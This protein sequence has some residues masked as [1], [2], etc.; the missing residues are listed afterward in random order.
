MKKLRFVSLLLAL[1]VLNVPFLPAAP[2][3][4]NYE[5]PSYTRKEVQALMHLLD[6][7]HY[8]RDA[9]T[10]KDFKQLI[11]DYMAELD[12]QRLFFT[13]EDKADFQKRYPALFQNLITLGTL[14]SAF[15]IYSLYEKRA[16]ERINWIFA[17][18]AK[19][20]DVS[21]HDSYFIDRSKA[22][23]AASGQ[24]S[25]E[26][27]RR[28]LKYEVIQEMLNK[29]TLDQAKT[30]V[31]E[32]YDRML[33]NLAEIETGDISEIFLST[34]TR[35]YD[36]HS[37]YFS[38][39]N[40]EDFSIQMRLS[41]V[42]IGAL[43]GTEDDNCVVKEII[44]GGPAD[45]SGQLHVNDK[46]V[47]VGN[48]GTEVVDIVGMK[49][50]KI[51][52]RIRGQKDTKVKLTVIPSDA[53]DT[54]TR[55]DITLVRDV[56][57]LESSRAHAAI[58]QVPTNATETVPIGVVTLPSFYGPSGEEGDGEKISATQDVAQLV[59]MLKKS[60]VQAMVLDLR[61]PN[62]LYAG[63]LAVL[64]SKFSA[65]ASEIVAGALQNYGRA[66]I[67]GDSSTHGKG[68]VQT[69]IEMKNVL[70]P[71]FLAS[72]VK[73]GA[74]K[75]TVQK[76]YLPNGSSTQLK[77]V[78]PDIALPSIDD[79]LPV[80][81]KDLPHALVWDEIKSTRFDGAPLDQ[82]I[83]KPLKESS[84]ERQAT[85]EEF[86]YLKKSIDWFKT[87]QDQ[88]TLS[89]NLDDRRKQKETDV[90]FRKEMNKEKDSLA[91][92]DF[93]FT[94]VTLPGTHPK[95]AKKEVKEKKPKADGEEG[96]EPEELSTEDAGS[97][98]KVD[99][100]LR[101]TLRVLN[102]ALNLSKNPQYWADGHPPLSIAVNKS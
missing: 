21:G 69:V 60:G 6:E 9:V 82:K 77:G 41:L 5:T 50:R 70:G 36:P 34:V 3:D 68:S 53:T 76:F 90:A 88:K 65:S 58:Y 29:K 61:D 8:N 11:P 54:S 43:L 56:V 92:N 39:E 64:T 30:K 80:G 47:A 28:R 97:P 22:E 26:L 84:Q 93:A 44:P 38:P 33:K 12:G 13:A 98:A 78:I 74:T 66:L 10:D 27:W 67:I 59:T 100:H 18:L 20:V 57:K 4:R 31:H 51:V 73:T 17:E 86:A 32:R 19:D 71:R 16:Q 45:L 52:D 24:E 2:S 99:I 63:P 101:E 14:D 25:D 49:L 40:F 96:D 95:P 85:L 79:F 91:K 87:K 94:E 1:L 35:L 42:G 46:I 48:D 102:D 81:E 55:K 89:L 72:P 23:W 62:L 83:I 7:Y 15:Q 37:T 75:L